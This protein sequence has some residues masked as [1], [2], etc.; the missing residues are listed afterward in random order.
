MNEEI[1]IRCSRCAF[2]K[3]GI[4]TSNK[5]GFYKS[6]VNPNGY[7]L[8]GH[9]VYKSVEVDVRNG[10]ISEKEIRLYVNKIMEAYPDALIGSVQIELDENGGVLIVPV[11]MRNAIRVRRV[12]IDE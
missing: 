10:Y 3:D 6:V 7:C 4:C 8:F 2:N 11:D 1:S 12:P 9:R 5:S